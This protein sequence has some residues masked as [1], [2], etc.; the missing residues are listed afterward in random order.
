MQ[1]KN[2]TVFGHWI[3]F[4]FLKIRLIEI[5]GRNELSKCSIYIIGVPSA[6]ANRPGPKRKVI[7]NPFSG[8]ILVSGR[9]TLHRRV[10]VENLYKL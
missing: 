8:S 9:E 2:T 6:L 1:N 7:V 5:H 10:Q 3:A 4:W